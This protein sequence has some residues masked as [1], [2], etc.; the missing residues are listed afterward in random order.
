LREGQ[1]AREGWEEL[2]REVAVADDSGL[3][4]EDATTITTKPFIPKQVGGRVEMKSHEKKT[5]TKQERK[6]REKQRAIKTK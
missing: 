6:R 5:G 4:K 3:K 2:W 1:E